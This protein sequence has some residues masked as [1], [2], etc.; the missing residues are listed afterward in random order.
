MHL[1]TGNKISGSSSCI[2]SLQSWEGGH[3]VV[4]NSDAKPQLLNSL[5]VQV[6]LKAC[7]DL[8]TVCIACLGKWTY[9]AY[10]GWCC[11]HS[12]ICEHTHGVDGYPVDASVL[13]LELLQK[14][15][16]T[17]TE[18]LEGELTAFSSGRQ[19]DWDHWQPVLIHHCH[20]C[21]GGAGKK[22]KVRQMQQKQKPWKWAFKYSPLYN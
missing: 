13:R 1:H 7:K 14:N 12:H 6:H 4:L 3:A 19:T 16:H 9:I 11:V 2:M 18:R 10:S 20:L 5:K 15:S 22:T 8:Y 17:V 21:E